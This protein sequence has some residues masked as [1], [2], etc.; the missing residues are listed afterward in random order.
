MLT[1]S[2]LELAEKFEVSR[3]PVGEAFLA[4]EKEGTAKPAMSAPLF[5]AR[6]FCG[7]A[8]KTHDNE[9]LR[10]NDSLRQSG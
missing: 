8:V 3:S 9:L 2:L 10:R 1:Y 6:D 5:S 4:L 7:L